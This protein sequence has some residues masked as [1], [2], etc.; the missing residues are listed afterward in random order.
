MLHSPSF[1]NENCQNK[2]RGNILGVVFSPSYL[3]GCFQLHHVI[4]FHAN[5]REENGLEEKNPHI[6]DKLFCD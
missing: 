5:P 2:N 4:A 1:C 3:S 6:L